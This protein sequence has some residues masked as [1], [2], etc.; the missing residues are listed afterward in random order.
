LFCFIVAELDYFFLT[1][2][3]S[4][5]TWYN[6]GDHYF[7]NREDCSR[8][9]EEEENQEEEECQEDEECVFGRRPI[10]CIFLKIKESNECYFVIVNIYCYYQLL[11]VLKW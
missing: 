9:L 8:A 4:S 6:F 2:N 11:L 3:N 10:Y 1:A 5:R 7:I